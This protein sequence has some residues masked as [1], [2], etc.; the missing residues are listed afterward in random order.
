MRIALA[1][2]STSVQRAKVRM[3]TAATISYQTRIVLPNIPPTKV[4][5]TPKATK[6]SDSPIT[7]VSES[8]K[9]RR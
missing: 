5:T 2:S 8:T 7:K 9:A 4:A 1:F 6:V 3:Q